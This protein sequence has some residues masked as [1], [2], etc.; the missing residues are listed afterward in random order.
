MNTVV[1]LKNFKWRFI[2]DSFH[3][4]N[5]VLVFLFWNA[6]TCSKFEQVMQVGNMS[7]LELDR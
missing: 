1:T 4:H 2:V 7:V 3:D 6:D 5:N